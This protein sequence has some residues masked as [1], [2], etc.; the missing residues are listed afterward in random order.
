[1]RILLIIKFSARH[2]REECNN[3]FHFL[4]NFVPFFKLESPNVPARENG[5]TTVQSPQNLSIRFKIKQQMRAS[6]SS[7][8]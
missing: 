6:H 4:S 5:D 1:M 7:L 8:A 2:V 3:N